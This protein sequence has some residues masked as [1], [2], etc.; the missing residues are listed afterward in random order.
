MISIIICGRAKEINSILFEN[1]KT[2][3]GVPFELIYIDNSKQVFDLF[4]AYNKGVMDAQYEHICFMHDDIT[5]ITANWGRL[6]IDKFSLSEIGA[7]GVAGTPYASYFPGTWWASTLVAQNIVQ[8]NKQ[9]TIHYAGSKL[10]KTMEPV[11]LLD[12]VWFCIRKSIFKQIQF[13]QVNYQGF[14]MYD[15]DI[16]MQVFE[17]GYKL[18]CVYDILLEHKSIGDLNKN[19][20]KNRIQFYKKW[21]NKLP[22]SIH[23]LSLFDKLNMEFK[24][25]YSFIKIL[26]KK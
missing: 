23:P 20:I 19:W 21:R 14:H 6:V 1:I 24:N 7:I 16:S 9:M 4:S 5:Y 3:I 17:K 26:L 22:I 18:F 13:D 15:M 12:G 25:L 10:N 8:E 2:T 11:I